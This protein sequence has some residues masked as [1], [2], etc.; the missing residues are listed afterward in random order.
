MNTKT[1]RAAEKRAAAKAIEAAGIRR[2]SILSDSKIAVEWRA[3]VDSAE[4][5]AMDAQDGGRL[6]NHV[7]I[8]SGH[9]TACQ[10]G[11]GTLDGT[12]EVIEVW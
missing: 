4:V 3:G 10:M 5:W 2:V 1:I 6:A 7:L 9:K 12:T 11:G 8:A